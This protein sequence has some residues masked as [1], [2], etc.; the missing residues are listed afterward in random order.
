[1]TDHV[2]SGKRHDA[3]QNP[4]VPDPLDI[5]DV[6]EEDVIQ[7]HWPDWAPAYLRALAQTHDYSSAAAQVGLNRCTPERWRK[8]DEQFA[9]ACHQA[10]QRAL[11]RIEEFL[12]VVGTSGLPLKRTVTKTRKTKDG[13]TVVEVTEYEDLFRDPKAAVK[14]L[15]RYRPEFRS[16]FRIEQSGP[17][18]GPVKHEVT[19]IEAEAVQDF[20][21]ALDEL[22]PSSAPA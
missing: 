16:S 7:P 17:G 22:V 4:G 6:T 10:R 19:V 8:A 2:S 11:D 3:A 5:P 21:T 12:F 13:E 1:M 9:V 20:Y 15:E 18:G 14:I